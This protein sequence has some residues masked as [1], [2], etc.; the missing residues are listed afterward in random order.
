[1]KIK[2]LHFFD[3]KK[4]NKKTNNKQTTKNEQQ[5]QQQ[6]NITKQKKETK[7]EGRG[8][9]KKIINRKPTKI[10]FNAKHKDLKT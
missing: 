7:I 4:Q 10:P 9:N 3:A 8:A 6:Q 5:Q 1:M 2:R